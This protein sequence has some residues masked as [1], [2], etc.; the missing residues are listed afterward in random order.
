MRSKIS[1]SR[2]VSSEKIERGVREVGHGGDPKYW[3]RRRAMPGP[4]TASRATARI[5]SS[6]SSLSAPLS[7]YPW[8]P[9]RMAVK[10]ESSSSRPTEGA[11]EHGLILLHDDRDSEK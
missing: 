4:K 7:R 3:I 10:T 9:A 8:A 1:R 6:I 11:I 2:L 5:A